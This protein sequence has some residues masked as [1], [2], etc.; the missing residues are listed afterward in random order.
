MENIYNLS[1]RLNDIS[2]QYDVLEAA[3]NNEY[4]ENGG[5][6]TEN[7]EM[8]EAEKETL[9]NIRNEILSEV[10]SL[11]DE[12][13]ALVKNEEAQKKILEAEL[14]ALKEEQAK[15]VAKYQ[16]RINQKTN[17]ISWFKQNIADA[18][19]LANL[20]RIGGPKTPNK[21]T[22][23]FTNTKSVVTDDELLLSPY[24]NEIDEL[25]SKLPAWLELK[26][27]ITKS[28]MDKENLPKG[29]ALEEKKNLQ[30]K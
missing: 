20:E 21:F 23:Y 19:K 1:A 30:I 10:I 18:M 17:K 8:M 24:I 9:E 28:A 13:A 2:G 16:A 4:E 15:V 12:Y 14:K 27:A 7:T 6:I 3:L 25:R 22:I 29:A 5:E 26:P 11:P